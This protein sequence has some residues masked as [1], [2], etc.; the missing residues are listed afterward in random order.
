MTTKEIAD[1]LVALCRQ[2]KFEDAQK[3]LYAQNAKSTEAEDSPMRPREIRGLDAIVQKG[4]QFTAAVEQIHK[5]S[6]S[7]PIVA[8]DA[9]ACTMSLDMTMKGRGRMQMSEVCVYDVKDGKIVAEQ[10]H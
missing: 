9:F 8:E 3:E 1:R 10:F 4:H 7:E 6:V 2:G 5:M